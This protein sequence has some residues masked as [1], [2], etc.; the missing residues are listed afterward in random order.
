MTRKGFTLVEMMIASSMMAVIG[1]SFYRLLAMPVRVTQRMDASNRQVMLARATDFI[2]NDIREADPTSL[3]WTTIQS[4]S[5]NPTNMAFK[6]THIDLST[7]DV[8]V[9]TAVNYTFQSANGS[10]QLMRSENGGPAT[11]II[12]NLDAPTSD[13]PIF[14]QDPTSYHVIVLTLLSHPAG[15]SLT[16]FTRRIALRG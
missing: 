6:K 8:P 4:G 1:F 10:G 14:L 5:T 7:P 9:T 3:D 11:Q 16:V 13:N 2:V 15:Q 12:S